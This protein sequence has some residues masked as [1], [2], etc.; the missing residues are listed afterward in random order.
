MRIKN[1]TKCNLTNSFYSIFRHLIF[2]FSFFLDFFFRF[3]LNLRNFGLGSPSRFSFS[4]LFAVHNGS[5]DVSP[6]ADRRRI[7]HAISAVTCHRC[8][9]RLR[10]AFPTS[11]AFPSLRHLQSTL[12]LSLSSLP[13]SGTPEPS[14]LMIGASNQSTNAFPRRR[15]FFFFSPI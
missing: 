8:L 14:C 7:F 5:L 9:S 12:S 6:F 13:A 10:R 4:L 1:I 15:L 11:D 3:S 2:T